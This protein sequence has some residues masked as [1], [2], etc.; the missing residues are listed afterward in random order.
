M[1]QFLSRVAHDSKFYLPCTSVV[2]RASFEQA[3]FQP[4]SAAQAFEALH[5]YAV[6]ILAQPWR[7]EFTKINVSRGL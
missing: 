6:R 7:A 4:L 1:S 2:L 5:E 3:N